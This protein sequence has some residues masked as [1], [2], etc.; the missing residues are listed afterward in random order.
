[1]FNTICLKMAIAYNSRMYGEGGRRVGGRGE[2][3]SVKL[4]LFIYL[5]MQLS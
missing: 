4:N 2:Y 5:N 1:M 3:F